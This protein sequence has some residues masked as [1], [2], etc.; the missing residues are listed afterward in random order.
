MFDLFGTAIAAVVAV[1]IGGIRHTS[2]LTL[3]NASVDNLSARQ[4][5]RHKRLEQKEVWEI[6]AYA[7][8]HGLSFFCFMIFI[9]STNISPSSSVFNFLIVLGGSLA[10]VWALPTVVVGIVRRF[11][12][13]FP[14]RK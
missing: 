4:V 5:R 13:F 10:L 8:G 1:V 6:A 3:R 11:L 12:S 2:D 14:R 9:G 7:W